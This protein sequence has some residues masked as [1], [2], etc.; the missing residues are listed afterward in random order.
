MNKKTKLILDEVLEKIN[1]SASE[2]KEIK[3][4]LDEFLEFVKKRLK[5][6][7]IDAEVF[8]GGSFAK[9]TIIK[10]NKYDIDIFLRFNKKHKENFSVLTKKVLNGIK[11]VKRVHGS[12]DYFRIKKNNDLFF[13]IIP[14]LKIKN[15]KGAEN[16]TDLSYSHVRYVNK[17]ANEK[18]L[19]E[20]KLAKAFCHA[21]NCYGA[22]SYINGFSG[23]A[24][25]LLIIYYGSFL[26]FLRE[27]LKVKNEKKII[28]IE[29][30]YKNKSF[31]LMDMNSSK[32][33]SPIILV[34][35]TCKQ[36]NALAA[37]S[38]ETFLK[39]QKGANKFLK[40]PSLNSF[41]KKK[42]DLEKIKKN[43]IKNKN[44]FIL[45]EAKTNKQK[46]DVAGSKLKKFYNHLSEEMKK[47]FVIK[48]NGFIYCEGKT[49][50]YFFVVKRKKEIIFSGPF[51]GDEKNIL[52]FKKEHK[53][54][55]FV[56]GKRIYAQEK[57]N[58]GINEFMNKWKKKNLK[59]VK[60]M[61][62]SGLRIL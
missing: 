40:S 30:L 55:T 4:S 7:N 33:S 61:C 9:K 17:K 28:D 47:Y 56:K 8:V 1:P 59:K 11:N 2:L 37:L 5:K 31:V 60:E 23:Y 27:I 21:K 38:N 39:F 18:I 54:K 14:V 52:K 16:I 43:A 6:L 34:D 13:E 50:N 3:N 41:E 53:G 57:I 19:N 25:E 58:F 20:I 51:L 10:K 22:E 35:P 45:I 24:L 12:R 26:K 32:L 44:E 62:I 49:A 42:T 29:K 48:K 36:R 46:G 15:S